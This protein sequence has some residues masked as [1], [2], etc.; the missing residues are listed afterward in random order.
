MRRAYLVC[1]LVAACSPGTSSPAD[2]QGSV[3]LNLGDAP[4][5]ADGD[6]WGSA[7][8]CKAIPDLPALV[9]P[10]ITI[11]L[12]GL[13][14]HLVDEASGYDKVF[15]IGPGQIETDSSAAAYGE[16]KSYEPVI[17]T[18]SRDFALSPKTADPCRTWWT[19]PDTGD[20]SP[21]FAGLPF[22]PFYGAYAMHGPIDHY[23]DPDGGALRRGFVSHGCVRMEA[24]DILEIYARTR[25]L[26]SVP[27]HLQREPERLTT[28][29]AVDVPSRW[30]GAECQ[31]D[32]DCN[33]PGGICRPSPFGGPGF[34]TQACNGLCPDRDGAPTTFCIADPS[35]A[36]SGVCVS[37]VVDQNPDCRAFGQMGAATRARFGD[38]S[39]TAEVCI[40]ASRGWIG[41][42]CLDDTDC[43][44]GSSC[45]TAAS[46]TPGL[47]TESCD[48]VCPDEPGFPTTAC[49]D[50]P[51]PGSSITRGCARRCTPASNASECEGRGECVLRGDQDDVYVC[52]PHA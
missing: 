39:T 11:S 17:A 13:T 22:M 27:V 30:I 18:G 41:D 15:P 50:D 44:D 32:G 21:V 31:V 40:P 8:T 5:G 36:D 45:A 51:V 26:D 23:R 9:Q 34:C 37:Q 24:A 38:P 33:Y 1:L 47:C 35:T 16:S 52:K 28:G 7:L 19:D 43:R 4:E 14:A 2:P 46:G 10:H 48:T 6:D 42:P 29:Q 12:N 3:D 25:T 49:A 20:Q